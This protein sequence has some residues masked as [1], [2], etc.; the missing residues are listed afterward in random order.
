[1]NN[2]QKFIRI[3]RIPYEE[4]HHLNLIVSVSNGT[5]TGQVE[6]YLCP[7]DLSVLA[8]NIKGF[9]SSIGHEYLW[10][11]GS[12][13]PSDNFA[14]YFKLYFYN[15]DAAGNCRIVCS[16]NNNEEWIGES[17]ISHFSL[18][19]RL[20]ELNVLSNLLLKLSGASKQAL[21]SC[22]HLEW[23]GSEGS[24]K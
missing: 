16:M 5:Q 24:V 2:P 22:T 8:E 14:F 13:K 17:E 18:D 1:M 19:C 3:E 9:P 7:D 15:V 4:P 12:D 23:T 6:I 11:L 20:E 21:K 10:E